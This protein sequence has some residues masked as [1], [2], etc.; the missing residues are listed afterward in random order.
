[1][2]IDGIPVGNYQNYS[3]QPKAI[4]SMIIPQGK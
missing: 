1:M 4:P 3:Q 2:I